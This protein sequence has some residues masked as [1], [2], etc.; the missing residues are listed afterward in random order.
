M[1]K[2]VVI[3]EDDFLELKKWCEIDLRPTFVPL[4]EIVKEVFELGWETGENTCGISMQT[5]MRRYNEE[6]NK[7]I[8]K[9]YLEQL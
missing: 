5:S 3:Y 7:I 8:S 1:K 9:D 2:A 4:E 6:F